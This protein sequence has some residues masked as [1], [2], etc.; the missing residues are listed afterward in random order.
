MGRKPRADSPLEQLDEDQKIELRTKLLRGTYAQVLAWCEDAF[1]VK[2][3]ISALQK[4][5]ERHCASY[6]RERRKFAAMKAS[7]IADLAKEEEVDWEAALMA[8]VQQLTFEMLQKENV[9]I[10]D[11]LKLLKSVENNRKIEIDERKVAIAEKKA[12]AFD[13]AQTV[14]EDDDLTEAEKAQQMKSLFGISG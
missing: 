6:V 14:L 3:S 7:E 8:E 13:E 10:K 2:T 11:V 1:G 5:Y 12:K 9:E 4:F